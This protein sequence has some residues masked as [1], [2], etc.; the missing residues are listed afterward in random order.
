MVSLQ[1]SFTSFTI[2]LTLFKYLILLD[3]SFMPACIIIY[4]GA[5]HK[6][7]LIWSKIS[8][9]D[10]PGYFRIFTLMFL[11]LFIPLSWMPFNIESPM[12]SIWDFFFWLSFA[13]LILWFFTSLVIWFYWPTV[14]FNWCDFFLLHLYCYFFMNHLYPGCCRI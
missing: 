1:V 5:F 4:S 11:S 12:I 7:G 10:V 2:F 8:I 6:L 9:E 13:D 14:L 3:M